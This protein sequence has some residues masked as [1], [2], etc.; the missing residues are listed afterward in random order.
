M[1][2]SI[3]INMFYL[4]HQET[5]KLVQQC[6]LTYFHQLQNIML[7]VIHCQMNYNSQV[8]Q[9]VCFI[10]DQFMSIF[11]LISYYLDIILATEHVYLISGT[12]ILLI[13]TEHATS[14][15]K[16]YGDNL[17]KLQ[18]ELHKKSM[19]GNL[20]Y[21]FISQSHVW[22]SDYAGIFILHLIHVTYPDGK[23]SKMHQG[24]IK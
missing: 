10:A 21:I 2:N 14:L 24:C 4:Q 19:R 23:L 16:S 15:C 5:L 3:L 8:C 9:K 22:W 20:P 11:F 12:K 1:K 18:A 7:K 17:V 6:Y 13:F